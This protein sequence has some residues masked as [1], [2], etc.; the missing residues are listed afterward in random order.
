M[1]LVTFESSVS[2]V[3]GLMCLAEVQ[4]PSS[5]S[6]EFHACHQFSNFNQ[7]DLSLSSRNSANFLP[8]EAFLTVQVTFL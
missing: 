7:K 6:Y 8:R 4:A 5:L 1:S 2:E 3:P